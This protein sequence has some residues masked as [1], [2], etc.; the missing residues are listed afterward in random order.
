MYEIAAPPFPGLEGGTFIRPSWVIVGA[1]QTGGVMLLASNTLTDAEL[2]ARAERGEVRYEDVLGPVR[3]LKPI[4][5]LTV[6]MP[7]FVMIHAVDYRSAFE[8]LFDQ[9]QPREGDQPAI[10]AAPW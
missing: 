7:N 3:P 2:R 10:G 6:V 1:E 5:T 8:A 9:W 4:Y